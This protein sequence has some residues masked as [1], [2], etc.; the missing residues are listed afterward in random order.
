MVAIVA[1]LMLWMMVVSPALSASDEPAQS[2]AE[3]VARGGEV[4]LI[5]NDIRCRHITSYTMRTYLS[6]NTECGEDVQFE[7]WEE[8][9]YGTVTYAFTPH[10]VV[11]LPEVGELWPEASSTPIPCL[12]DG[13]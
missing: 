5:E 11:E 6:G 7:I 3:C 12:D 8:I 4:R 10:R 1:T 2:F 13:D 9:S